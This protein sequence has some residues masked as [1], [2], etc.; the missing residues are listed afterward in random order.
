MKSQGSDLPAERFS[1]TRMQAYLGDAWKLRPNL[2][3]TIGVQYVRDTGRSNSDLPAIPC[4]AVAASY[5]SQAPC[6][7]SDDLLTHFGGIFPVGRPDPAT[8][9]EFRSPV[10]PGVGPGKAWTYRH[11]G[12]HRDVLRQQC[13]RNLVGGPCWPGWRTAQFNA[14]ANDPCASHGDV[15]FPGNIA[16]ERRGPLRAAHRKRGDR[17]WRIL[18]TR[19]R[20]RMPR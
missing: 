5:G 18:Q 17:K 15:I 11:P 19:S 4:S 3:M 16:A 13:F 9:P 6:T 1:D 2:T 14:Q 12:R 7:G 20:R 8:Q 10:W